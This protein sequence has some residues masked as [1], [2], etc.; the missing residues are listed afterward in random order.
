MKQFGFYWS[1]NAVVRRCFALREYVLGGDR[2]LVTSYGDLDSAML[3]L[4]GSFVPSCCFDLI[5]AL[6]PLFAL[7]TQYCRRGDI[8]RVQSEDVL[9]GGCLCTQERCTCVRLYVRKC[10]VLH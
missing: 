4:F 6:G 1:C 2:S 7:G 10:I 8:V 3:F 9:S 5:V